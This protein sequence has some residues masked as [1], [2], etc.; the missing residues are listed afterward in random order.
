MSTSP[1]EL[2]FQRYRYL[3]RTAPPDDLEAAHR[4]AFEQLTPDQRRRVL[5]GLAA[6][7]GPAEAGAADDSPAGLARL[8][9]RAEL[10]QPGTMERAFG[11]GGPSGSGGFGGSFLGMLAGAFVGTS[12]ANALF[13]DGVAAAD[14]AG[15]GDASV[16]ESGDGGVG[17]EDDGGRVQSGE[18]GESDDVPGW[19]GGD[20][21][22]FDDVGGGFDGGG[23][24][25]GF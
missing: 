10:R 21:G 25:L 16:E 8:A 19:D 7:V 17:L 3:L 14:D 13:P 2:A 22:G 18:W 24:D 15:M 11:G 12:I 6:Q 9:T 20:G 5:E 4:E 1:D 23:F